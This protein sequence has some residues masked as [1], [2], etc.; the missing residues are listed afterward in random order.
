M[1]TLGEEL[2]HPFELRI[3]GSLRVPRRETNISDEW[4]TIRTLACLNSGIEKKIRKIVIRYAPIWIIDIGKTDT[5]SRARESASTSVIYSG[6]ANEKNAFEVPMQPN[7]DA[8][9]ICGTSPTPKS[10]SRSSK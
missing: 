9:L 10:L 2:T 4:I 7:I 6:F 8:G 1:V 5:P 3:I